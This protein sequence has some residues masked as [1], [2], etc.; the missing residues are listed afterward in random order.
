M[1]PYELGR[2]RS[3]ASDLVLQICQHISSGPREP[4]CLL[5]GA[6]LAQTCPEPVPESHIIGP[7]PSIS[8]H[9]AKEIKIKLGTLLQKP[10]A[11]P[12]LAIPYHEKLDKPAKAQ[13]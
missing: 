9:R 2:L 6:L 8:A 3:G 7:I 10:E 11:A 12:Q 4:S 1:V 13:K 5:L